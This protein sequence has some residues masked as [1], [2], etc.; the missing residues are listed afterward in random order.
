MITKQDLAALRKAETVV[1]RS[2]KGEGTLEVGIRGWG[3]PVVYSAADQ[4]LFP[5]TGMAYDERRRVISVNATISGFHEG[6]GIWRG[7]DESSAFEMI[8]GGPY[9]AVWTTIV[10]LLRAGDRV[11]LAFGADA[12]NN[13]YVYSANLH[14]DELR[15]LV[16]R[17]GKPTMTFLIK[18]SV[19]ADNTARMVQR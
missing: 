5:E 1:F 2:F 13:G 11:T 14:A 16:E 18:V 10:G 4:R 12:H 19:C 9:N 6:S 7:D 8:H 15:L 3:D 17:D